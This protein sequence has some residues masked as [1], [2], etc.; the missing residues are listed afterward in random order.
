MDFIQP[1]EGHLLS[2]PHRDLGEIGG[3]AKAGGYIAEDRA[4]LWVNDT[5]STYKV[6]SPRTLEGAVVTLDGMK[7]G[8]YDVT[9]YNTY[10][11]E[12]VST[13]QGI[14]NA[15]GLRLELPSF[16][17]DLAVKAVHRQAGDDK[18]DRKAP[19]PP[20]GVAAT[21]T[22]ERTATLSWEASDDHIGVV[23]YDIFRDGVFVGETHGPAT[24]FKDT[25]LEPGT[26][27]SYTVVARD[28]AGNRSEASAP[29]AATTAESDAEAPSAPSGLEVLDVGTGTV[30]LAW[31]ASTDDR[32][33][34]SYLVYRDGVLFGTTQSTTLQD[35]G[36]RP[37]RTYAY[38]VKAKDAAGNVSAASEVV[39]ATTEAPAMTPN[40]LPNPGFE[41]VVDGKPANWTCEQNWYCAS[42]LVEKRSG[43]ASLKIE[44]DTGAWFGIASAA[45]SAI[46]GN[47]YELDGYV[48]ISYNFGAF[49]K[50]RMQFLNAVGSIL[51]DRTVHVYSGT[52]NGFENVYGAFIA[53]AHTA[54]VRVYAY[55]EGL[56]ATIRLDDFSIRGYGPHTQPEEPEEPTGNL[57]LNGSFDERNDF[58]KTAIW[59][60]EKEWLCQW[61]DQVKR[62]DGEG[63]ASMRIVTYGPDWFGVYQDAVASAGNAYAFDGYVKVAARSAGKLQAKLAFYDDAGAQLSEEWLADLDAAGDAWVR[64]Q[65]AKTAPAGAAKVRVLI[66]A[67]GFHGDAYLDDFSLV[68]Q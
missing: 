49:L 30:D 31:G 57:L 1:E 45:G 17:R 21:A 22:T 36:L 27:Y 29:A 37:G 33:V 61:T 44:G 14:A 16:A 39:Q 68:R 58:W 54:K 2:M 64:V 32:A 43:D 11:G 18:N 35:D 42:D 9:Y 15:Q 62:T 52:T 67:N 65:G 19:T 24:T 10:T 48:N 6:A 5:V 13:V 50:V 3:G 47:T 25:I 34:H 41:D 40:L 7:H 26:T 23:G 4:L 51:D 55:I 28:A 46:A 56:N 8:P 60:C 12:T 59:T 20:T 53:P 63:T 38:T 66:Y